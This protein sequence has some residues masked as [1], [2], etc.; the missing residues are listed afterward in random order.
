MILLLTLALV[1]LCSGYMAPEYIDRLILSKECDIFSLGVIIVEIVTGRRKYPKG[2]S[3][4]EFIEVWD[5]I[6]EGSI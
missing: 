1:L 5:F 6:S 4:D 3:S 2:T